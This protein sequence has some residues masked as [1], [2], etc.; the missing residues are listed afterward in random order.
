M[1]NAAS[2][3]HDRV[4]TSSWNDGLIDTLAGLGVLLMGVSWQFDLV[5]MGSIAPALMIPLWHPLRRKLVEPRTGYMEFGV[6]TQLRLSRSMWMMALLGAGAFGIG[7]AGYFYASDN[8]AVADVSWIAALPAILIGIGAFVAGFA[9]GIPRFPLYALVF[10]LCGV[11][12]AVLGLEPGLAMIAGGTV[13]AA[14]GLWLLG[15]FLREH[16]VLE[17]QAE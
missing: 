2:N 17:E 14:T 15:R 9:F 1:M 3:L 11:A 12:T 10:V 6:P 16:P 5:P 8:L 7:V 13:A 4:L